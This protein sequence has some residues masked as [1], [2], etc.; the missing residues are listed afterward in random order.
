MAFKWTHNLRNSLAETQTSTNQSI[1]EQSLEQKQIVILEDE[2]ARESM[3]A[4]LASTSQNTEILK[5]TVREDRKHTIPNFLNRLYTIDNFTWTK[6]AVRGEVLKTYRFPDKL[7]S[8]PAIAGKTRNFFGFRAGV[9]LTVL[10]NKQPFQAGNLMISYLPHAKY[11][12]PKLALH[13]DNTGIVSRSG[14]PRTNLDLMDGTRA[15]LK[16][17]YASPFV[18]YNLLTN[19]GTIGDFM[20]SVYSP[21]ADEASAG[22]VSVQV[23]ARFIDIDLQFPTGILPA[24]SD[25]LQQ[26]TKQLAL[27]SLSK[28]R[29]DMVEAQRILDET[30]EQINS[31]KFYHQMNTQCTNMKQKA[32]PNMTNSN[33]QEHAHTISIDANNS[34]KSMNF[35]K[36]GPN[37]MDIKH[38]LSIP[39]YHNAFS[40]STA[41]AAGTTVYST[42]V[43]PTVL[44]NITGRPG[45]IVVDYM[46]FI[47][48]QHTKWRGSFKFLFYA[49]KTQFHSLRIRIWFCPGATSATGV[50]KDSCISKIVDLKELNT[51][52]FE[53]PFVW[54]LPWLNCTTAPNSLGVLGVDVI[55]AMVAPATV[56]SSIDVIVERAMGSDFKFNKPTTLT[57]MPMDITNVPT[58][59]AM[60]REC[61]G[62]D[63]TSFCCRRPSLRID[64][65]Q[66]DL[67]KFRHQMNTHS[68]QDHMHTP[69][70]DTTFERPQSS[71]EADELTMGQEI[72]NISQHLKRST[73]YLRSIQSITQPKY[74]YNEVPG[75]GSIS[76]DAALS[77]YNF[78]ATAFADTTIAITGSHAITAIKPFLTKDPVTSIISLRLP[79]DYLVEATATYWSL[80][81][82]DYSLDEILIT[83]AD[84]TTPLE[85][86]AFPVVTITSAINTPSRAFS[87][88]PHHL[89][90]GYFDPVGGAF[91]VPTYDSLTYYSSLYAFARGSVNIRFNTPNSNYLVTLNSE[92]VGV[93]SSSTG[94]D[95]VDY[96]PNTT[97][98]SITQLIVPN[99]EGLGEIHVPYYASSYCTGINNQANFDPSAS[100]SSLNEPETNILV[101]PYGDFSYF[102]MYRAAGS[103]FEFSYLTGPPL[104][105]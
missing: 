40:I 86:E 64:I 87:I 95:Q 27:F 37:E 55:N 89:P 78:T 66:P 88:F 101:A 79:G 13:N 100:F 26:V 73:R 52:E 38:I 59:P 56:S 45:T 62:P 9:E 15:T 77:Q 36:A 31:G 8:N 102:E 83:E 22:T 18:Y 105:K 43:S 60:Y 58:A 84:N 65:E 33:G 74:R 6:T 90:M 32:L 21:L 16:V 46:N 68:E 24:T 82:S 17:P 98:S 11:N 97:T 5:Q 42:V 7:L 2:G 63:H 47:S 41:Q 99:V 28:D 96:D 39:C 70:D 92:N 75:T 104:I 4:P 67:T 91:H 34:L 103:D 54:P 51:A 61:L 76:Y 30:L 19:E 12:A 20:I 29:G 50:D 69:G 57:S 81:N 48:Q 93:A 23:M 53:V 3:I 1:T 49:V 10:V 14:A 71:R 72:S 80:H 94:F 35:G 44:P 25:P 85:T